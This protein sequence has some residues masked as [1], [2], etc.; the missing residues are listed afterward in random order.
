MIFPSF[1]YGIAFE[2]YGISGSVAGQHIGFFT[3]DCMTSESGY[4]IDKVWLIENWD[5]KFSGILPKL[6]QTKF[7]LAVE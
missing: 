7:A 4:E 6:N 5:R 1:R 2:I 3:K